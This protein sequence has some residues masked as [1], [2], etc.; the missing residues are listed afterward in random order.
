[1]LANFFGKSKPVNFLVIFALFLCL[2]SISLLTNNQHINNISFFL[3]HFGKTLVLFLILF[4]VYNFILSKNELTF[5]NSYAFLFFVLLIGLFP[6]TITIDKNFY[7]NLTL[8]LALRKIYSLQSE[9]STVKKLF[10]GGFWLGICFIIEPF[11]L[12]FCLLFY[13]AIF[14][15]KKITIQTLL[16]PMIGFFVP[17]FLYFTYCFWHDNMVSFLQLFK[18]FTSY[19]FDIYFQIKYSYGIFLVLFLVATS[20][21]L[22]TPKALAVNNTFK[23]NWILIMFN[24]LVTLFLVVLSKHKNGGELL[25]TFFPISIILANGFELLQKKWLKETIL[26]LLLTTSFTASLFL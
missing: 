22:K 4:S 18:W 26:A 16:V 12:I 23:G 5:D 15:H 21:L 20:L 2:S 14:L 24:L 25:F 9:K 17:I 3:K 11:S 6:N 8:F 13:A 1:M 10:D 7:I 19:E